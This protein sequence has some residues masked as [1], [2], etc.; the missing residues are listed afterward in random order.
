MVS[1]LLRYKEEYS[2]TIFLQKLKH[3]KR[4]D[5][6]KFELGIFFLCVVV[7]GLLFLVMFVGYLFRK[8]FFGLFLN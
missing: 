5:M 3:S 6:S 4:R 2:R 7:S 1:L 8:E